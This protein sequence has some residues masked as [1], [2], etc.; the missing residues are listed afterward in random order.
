MKTVISWSD[1]SEEGKNVET[2]YYVG[3]FWIVF[4][5]FKTQIPLINFVNILKRIKRMNFKCTTD[6]IKSDF[7]KG[8][9]RQR[10]FYPK[11]GNSTNNYIKI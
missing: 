3:F 8:W 9:S 11:P 10:R 4:N 1:I 6:A 7:K 2:L 5:I